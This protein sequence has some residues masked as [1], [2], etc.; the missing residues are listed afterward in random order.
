MGWT[1]RARATARRDE[2]TFAD[3]YRAHL[4]FVWRTL[5]SLGVPETYV[6]DATHDVFV[7][8]HRRWNDWDRHGKV[9]SLLYGISRG[10]ARNLHRSQSRAERRLEVVRNSES[11][12][13]N[14]FGAPQQRLDHAEAARLLDEFLETL[15]PVKREAFR[16]CAIE[17]LTAREAATC[18]GDSPNTVATRVRRA[19]LAF[20]AFVE[21]LQREESA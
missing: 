19:R 7:V 12:P 1:L 20:E 21:R 5:R 9:T 4:G 14:P 13:P 18:L 6:E 3:I 2:P 10:V 16:L 11:E 17:G 8:L 15:D